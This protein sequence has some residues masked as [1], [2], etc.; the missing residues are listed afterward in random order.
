MPFSELPCTRRIDALCGEFE[1]A[2]TAGQPV[3]I[4]GLLPQAEPGQRAAL[5][6]ELIALEYELRTAGGE[7]VLLSEYTTRFPD[8]EV[9]VAA[10]VVRITS[11]DLFQLAPAPRDRFESS[12]EARRLE[13]GEP[14]GAGGMGVVY[15][16]RDA[17]LDRELAVKLLPEDAQARSRVVRRFVREARICAR[18]EHPGI[19]PVHEMGWLDQRPYFTMK[20]VS[21][22][23]FAEVLAARRSPGDELPRML[24]I[25]GRV[26]E[27]MAYAH[28]H[29][30]VHRDLKPANVMLGEFGEVYVIDWGLAKL[31]TE[32]GSAETDELDERDV[33]AARAG[34]AVA[35]QAGDS[36]P[37]RRDTDR[38][39]PET[40][41]TVFGTVI[42]TPRY[43]AP[44]QAAGHA[45]AVDRR[46]DVYGL[47]AVLCEILTGAPP[48]PG[49]AA[50][51]LESCSAD[52]ALVELAS[53]CLAHEPGER[54]PDA[55]DVSRC[56]TAYQRGVED[57][58][59]Q[60]ELELARR[61]ER[62]RRRLVFLGLAASVLLL[63]SSL[64]AGA[65]WVAR[66][67]AARRQDQARLDAE[68]TERREAVARQ[69]GKAM[70][71]AD[72]LYAAGPID[73]R[74]DPV[75]RTRILEL[76][77]RAETL[78]ETGLAEPADVR[79]VEALRGRIEA[80]D[81]DARLVGRLDQI[82]R[83]RTEI[84]PGLHPSVGFQ[85]G[86]MCHT[87]FSIY[88]LE[89][90]ETEVGV[91]VAKL[92][93]RPARV[94]E[95][96]ILPLECW[97][98]QLP[99]DAPEAAWID[100]VL[101][102]LGGHTWLGKA[103][104]ACRNQD[105]PEAERLLKMAGRKRLP[106][107]SVNLIAML[108][109]RGGQ[110]E[111]AQP[112]LRTAQRHYPGDFWINQYLGITLSRQARSDLAEAIR[113]HSAALAIRETA[114]THQHLA[115]LFAQLDRDAE[116]EQALRSAASLQPDWIVP[117]LDL[118]GLLVRRGRLEEALQCVRRAESAS[119]D[120]SELARAAS[121][122]GQILA[123]LNRPDKA[124]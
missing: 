45:L 55:G 7:Q 82:R 42:G 90:P 36:A 61:D 105:W 94:A 2:W 76:A 60:T 84:D 101:D 9:A 49:G 6:S 100:A 23:S 1:S 10:A 30:V 110:F 41:G 71:V 47:G 116:A 18:L 109:I 66:R 32:A 64:T 17:L 43:M 81:S 68:E 117:H 46:S 70:S 48:P 111:L 25:F 33:A 124:D 118:A 53:R 93:S 107:D 26:C 103:R 28:A 57:R 52:R 3:P 78:V 56:L 88:G 92:R 75:R 58:L 102:Q 85:T 87:A 72:K 98:M 51:V 73:W 50:T 63:V 35:G 114:G 21:G 5:L 62:R 31:L 115:T 40:V 14:L 99:S 54:P 4:E 24:G 96:C 113:F 37:I 112:L 38:F 20:L 95:A 13:L 29:G 11:A 91:A 74:V 67:D 86:P 59:R 122:G 19:V 123:S 15:R 77:R 44:E 120:R 69:L 65:V 104:L 89:I 22:R 83:E 8:E 119:A 39:A 106:A 79:R 97:R 121:L 12:L 27:T 80:D 108:L 16:G 34:T